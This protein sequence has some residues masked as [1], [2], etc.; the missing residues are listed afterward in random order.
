M[1]KS[2]PGKRRVLGVCCATHTLHD[3]LSD[4]SYVLLPVLA[5]AFGLS[6]AQAGLIRSA[7]R[8]AMAAFQ[9]PAG[10]V[11][12]RLGERNLLAFGTVCAGLAFLA[13]GISGSFVAVLIALFIAG[14]GSAFQH[15]LCSTLISHAYADK[16][17]RGALGT[18]NF[19]GDVGKF[20]F[21]GVASLLFVAGFAWHVPVTLFGVT[22]LVCA[23]AIM[24][25]V[26]DSRDSR[27]SARPLTNAVAGWGIR[28][29]RGFASLCLIHIVDNATRTGFLTFVAFLMMAKGIPEGW[30]AASVP[31]VLVG[32]MAGKLACGMLAERVGI[33]RTAAATEAAT[34]ISIL[35][36]VMLPGIAAYALLPFIG[37][38]LNGTSS[39]LYGTIGELVDKERLSRAFGLFYTIGSA[40]GIAAPLA[41]G[42]IGD[43]I[44][45][46]NAIVL[47]GAVAFLALPGCLLLKPA[48]AENKIAEA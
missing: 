46:G 13:L 17:R 45:V 25:L 35:V 21:G 28:N 33:I 8:M 26:V 1:M 15:P 40:T 23:A 27:P 36:L 12:E 31:L 30:A 19:A 38:A 2:M 48:L 18:Y 47:A 3:G 41:Y 11:A 37:I 42:V 7:H 16:S 14:F 29:R 5:Q 9:M 6:L 22:A 10:I 20:A 43:R 4:V 44:G 39:V 32:G 34:A 24:L